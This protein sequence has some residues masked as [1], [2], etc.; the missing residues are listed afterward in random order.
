MRDLVS[1]GQSSW[2]EVDIEV[3][4]GWPPHISTHVNRSTRTYTHYLVL[5]SVLGMESLR[6]LHMLGKH[7]TT[8]LHL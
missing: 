1:I 2:R 7:S 6:V 3:D 5:F 4:N 8:E